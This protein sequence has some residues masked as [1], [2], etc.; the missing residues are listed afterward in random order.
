MKTYVKYCRTINPQFTRESAAILKEEYK[1][2]RQREKAD[3]KNAYKVTVRQLESLIRLSEAISRAHCDTVI[4]PAYVREVCRLLKASNISIQR[5]DVEFEEIQEEINKQRADQIR[6]ER[7][8]QPMN[9]DGGPAAEQ[10]KQKKVKITF[11]EYQQ[12]AQMIVM[13]IKEFERE[14]SDNVQ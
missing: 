11:T 13:T 3:Q 8:A 9:V 14:G 7:D 4:K 5:T 1:M 12:L 6:D 2:M 10:P